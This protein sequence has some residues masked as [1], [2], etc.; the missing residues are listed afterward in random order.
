VGLNPYNALQPFKEHGGWVQSVS[1]SSDGTLIASDG[2]D[3][4]V[5]FYHID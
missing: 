3:G 2:S 1:F 4:Q 5:I